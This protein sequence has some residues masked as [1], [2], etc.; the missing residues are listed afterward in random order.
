[1][2]QISGKIQNT[3]S[4]SRKLDNWNYPTVTKEIELQN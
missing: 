3:K 1:M 2:I 4:H